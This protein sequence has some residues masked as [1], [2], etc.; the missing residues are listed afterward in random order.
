[1]HKL[2]KNFFYL[3]FRLNAIAVMGT[4]KMMKAR[5]KV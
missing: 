1:M 3:S 4:L 5:L 2:L